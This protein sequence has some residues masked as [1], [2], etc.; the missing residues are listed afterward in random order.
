[1]PGQAARVFIHETAIVETDRIGA[2]TRVWAFAHIMPDVTVGANCNVG[3]H[4]FIETGAR[5]GENVTVKNGNMVW[6]GVTLEDGVFVGPHV[7]FTNDLYPRSPRLPQAARRYQD[8]S[9]MKPTVIRQGAS[10][11]AGSVIL[12]GVT[13]G[14][15]SM[16]AAGAVVTRDV[17]PYT[18]VMGNP[19]R[20]RSAVCECGQPL[21]GR[22]RLLRCAAC[23]RRFTR[24]KKGV[25]PSGSQARS[26]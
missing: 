10:L 16:V 22:A 17:P 7:F 24:N 15:Y 12:A 23:G 4:C 6:A 3:D 18:L 26:G 13:V 1:M 11:G 8:Q 2:G 21:K 20:A 9:W 14:D 25:R 19:A 5:I